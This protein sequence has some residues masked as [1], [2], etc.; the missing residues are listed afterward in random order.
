MASLVSDIDSIIAT[1][2]RLY[3]IEGRQPEISLLHYSRYRLEQTEY[4]NWDG[5][6]YY[7][8]LIFEVPPEL[9]AS[10]GDAAEEL[11]NSILK[12]FQQS[13][14]IYTHESLTRVMLIP[15]L[16]QTGL[17]TTESSLLD[18]KAKFWMKH[19]FRLFISHISEIKTQASELQKQL[20]NFGISAFVAHEDI[21]PT[22]EWLI[23]I[24]L[25]LNTMDAMVALLSPGFKESDWTSQEVGI[26][27][28]KNTLIIP[29]RLGLDPY[30]FIGRYQGYQGWDKKSPE[31]ANA[32]FDILSRHNLT[33]RKIATCLVSLLEKAWTWE[34][35]RLYMGLIEKLPSL[36][37]ALVDRLSKAA[38]SNIKVAEAHGVPAKI[39][40][41]VERYKS[42]NSQIS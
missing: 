39:A 14:K 1:L 36:D 30:G 7:Y 35:A 41:L 28:G 19:H 42:A 11:E 4:D 31:I 25:A 8:S 18:R 23:E 38:T 32:I 34:N 27:I 22:K 37:K 12:R 10:L 33:A 5:G 40:G 9:F 26:G 13:T 6:T 20:A 3:E 17:K 21:V 2:T 15:S 16:E 24:D 29:V